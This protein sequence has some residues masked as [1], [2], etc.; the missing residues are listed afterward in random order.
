MKSILSALLILFVATALSAKDELQIENPLYNPKEKKLYYELV[1][2]SGQQIVKYQYDLELKLDNLRIEDLGG[3]GA[4]MA[5][6]ARI[7]HCADLTKHLSSKLLRK[8]SAKPKVKIDCVITY[9]ELKDG[10]VSRKFG[11]ARKTRKIR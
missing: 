4:N 7:K 3:A 10:T 11:E 2:K 6:D 5:K 1:N 8:I 9:L